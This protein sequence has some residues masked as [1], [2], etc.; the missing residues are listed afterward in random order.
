MK[1]IGLLFGIACA[2]AWSAANAAT[3]VEMKNAKG[4]A[5]GTA[6][7]TPLAKGVKI[8]LDV[9]GLP[10]G[11]HGFH[12]HENGSC[13]APKFD[14]AGGHFAPVKHA[15]GFDNPKGMHAGDMANILVATDGTA[16][17]EVINTAV[18]MGKGANSLLKKG[19]TALVIHEKA[20]DYKSQP[21]G[22]AGSRLACGEVK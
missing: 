19:G 17:V 16:K 5:V 3:T 6:V 15:H 7:L 21:S 13:V 4:E 11:E 1:L 20:D 10:P 18:T 22:D 14:S 2:G 12:V 8:S 9:H